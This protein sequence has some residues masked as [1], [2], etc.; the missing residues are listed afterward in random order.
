MPAGILLRSCGG[1]AGTSWARTALLQGCFQPQRA[2]VP[3]LPLPPSL[4]LR[5]PGNYCGTKATRQQLPTRGDE[6][7]HLIS[8]RAASVLS[9]ENVPSA[10]AGIRARQ[11]AAMGHFLPR[12]ETGVTT[13]TRVRSERG[14]PSPR[15]GGE[16]ARGSRAPAASSHGCTSTPK[17]RP[18]PP[19]RSS[20]ARRQQRRKRRCLCLCRLSPAVPKGC[21]FMFV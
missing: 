16:A 4:R 21:D 15:C 7:T 10:H 6:Y 1:Q 13:S 19:T 9:F 5:A 2:P 14:H 17:R 11:H 18:L 20:S 3:V 8:D 12:A